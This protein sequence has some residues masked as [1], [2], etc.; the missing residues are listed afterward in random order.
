MN[1]DLFT[2]PHAP[3]FKAR[4]TARDS[5]E[6]MK[7]R[8]PTIRDRI[9]GLLTPAFQCTPDEAADILGIS[10]LSVRP[11]FSELEKMGKIVDSGERRRNESGH[12]AIVWRLP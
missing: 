6:A 7:P 5:A 1:H 10:I 2:Y 11:R 3:G 4:D 8:A 12:K 9:L